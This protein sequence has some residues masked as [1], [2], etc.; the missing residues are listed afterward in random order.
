MSEL[1]PATPMAR[2]R[3]ADGIRCSSKESGASMRAIAVTDVG[4]PDRLQLMDLPVP[5]PAAGEV[6]VRVE[7]AGVNEVDGMFREGYLDS[8]ARPLVMGSDLSG[9]VE[10]VGPDVTD[11][12]PGDGVFG[13]KLLGNGTYAEYATMPAAWIA[14]KPAS[15]SHEEAAALPCVGL[16]A[17]QCLETLRLAP[18][19]VL[20]VTA[21]AGGVGSVAVQVAAARGVRVIGTAS[22]RNREYVLDLGAEAFI[23]YTASDWVAAVRDL[24]PGGV[25]AVLTCRG[26]ETKRRSPGALRDGGRFVWMTGEEKAGPPME[27]GIAGAYTGGSPSRETLVA[28][29]GE[30]DD[31]RL[32]VFL[33]HVFSLH[34]AAA[35][36]ERVATGH[37]RGKLVIAVAADRAGMV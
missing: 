34:E 19:E 3:R 2:T 35:A 37:V 21:A 5:E 12:E 17:L 22:A 10:R 6:L 18:G 30:A 25:D 26:G 20:V 23:D 7:A 33:E 28:L 9:I 8:G 16:T 27:R 14:R 1:R 36:Q 11:L 29:A 4:G 13:Y 24:H 15:L 31:G 32:R